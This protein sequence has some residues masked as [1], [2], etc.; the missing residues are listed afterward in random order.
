[1]HRARW[2]AERLH[3]D[4]SVLFITYTSNLASDIKE[5]LKTLC[6]KE[7][8]RRIEVT[9]LDSWVYR[10]LKGQRENR[11]IAYFSDKEVEVRW[12]NALGDLD[13]RYSW[14]FLRDE[15][16]EII[17]AHRI[18]KLEEYLRV[19]RTG[20]GTSIS[21]KERTVLWKVFERYSEE[22][23]D[24][25]ILEPDDA[26]HLVCDILQA[27]SPKQRYFSCILDEAQD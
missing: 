2:V 11:K 13:E 25:G 15:W 7:V 12:K 24:D 19:S 10:F 21:R 23:K 22:L 5:Q 9:T 26:Y 20:R 1:M 14:K 27:Q 17:Q 8:F 18:S 4:R 3:D 6:S 16:R